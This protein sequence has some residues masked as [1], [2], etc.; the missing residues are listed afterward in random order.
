MKKAARSAHNSIGKVLYFPFHHQILTQG[1]NLIKLNFFTASS[2][3]FFSKIG[4]SHSSFT[5]CA[6]QWMTSSV[7]SRCP[8]PCWGPA[9]PLLGPDT[10]YSSLVSHLLP[11]SV[12][13]CNSRLLCLYSSAESVFHLPRV[14]G[15][16]LLNF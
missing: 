1:Q 3:T 11:C 16:F 9:C 2:R 14:P 12:S 6:G 8:D 4:F 15:T 7:G 13:S 10:A 5:A